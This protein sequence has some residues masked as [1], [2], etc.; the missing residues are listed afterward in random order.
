MCERIQKKNYD[1]NNDILY[2]TFDN[3]KGT[4]YADA[5]PFGIEIMRDWDTEEV[6]GLMIYYPSRYM[7]DRQQKLDSMGYHILL[8]E[9]INKERPS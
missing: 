2:I 7:N 8:N 4:S 6:T 9:I 5:G 1:Q 3:A